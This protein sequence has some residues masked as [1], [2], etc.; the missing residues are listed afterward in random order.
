M[1]PLDLIKT[2][3]LLANAGP[4]APTQA[5]LRRAVSTAY[6]ALFHALAKS[7]ADSITG[8]SR[9]KRGHL[10]WRQVYR[11]LEHGVVKNSLAANGMLAKFPKVIEDFGNHFVTMQ[12]KRHG[13]DYDPYERFLKSDV[14]NDIDIAESVIVD[15]KTAPQKDKKAFCALVLFKNR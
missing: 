10:A 8:S 4:G 3:R 5:N 11:S 15:V 12:A 6:Y 13:A 9:G 1:Q 7:C 14:I 2:A